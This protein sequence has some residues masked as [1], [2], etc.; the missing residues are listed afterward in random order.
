[1]YLIK[2]PRSTPVQTNAV[3]I[4]AYCLRRCSNIKTAFCETQWRHWKTFQMAT[5]WLD[6]LVKTKQVK[7]IEFHR[8]GWK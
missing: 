4:L 6:C 1:M 3:L 5:R 2:L 8:I 7:A